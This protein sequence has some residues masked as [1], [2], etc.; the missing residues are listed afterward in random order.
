M[1]DFDAKVSTLVEQLNSLKAGGDCRLSTPITIRCPKYTWVRS[2]IWSYE[3]AKWLFELQKTRYSQPV[4]VVSDF[5]SV[6][7]RVLSDWYF[8]IEVKQLERLYERWP[9]GQD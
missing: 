8:E 9:W 6:F 5:A 4:V 1:E 7:K 3:E 2:K